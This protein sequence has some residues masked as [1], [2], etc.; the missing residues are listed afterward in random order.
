[1]T[2]ASARC[3]GPARPARQN[4][5]DVHSSYV[6]K[7]VSDVAGG[8]KGVTVGEEEGGGLSRDLGVQRTR[9]PHKHVGDGVSSMRVKFGADRGCA[10]GRSSLTMWFD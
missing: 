6:A 8:R 5:V 4:L 1:M 2:E 9:R 7:V 10:W 3:R